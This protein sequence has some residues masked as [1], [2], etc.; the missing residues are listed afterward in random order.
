M[1][2]ISKGQHTDHSTPCWVALGCNP[3]EVSSPHAN[4]VLTA[5]ERDFVHVCRL[6][7]WSAGGRWI[8]WKADCGTPLLNWVAQA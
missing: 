8:Y 3:A 5:W 2:L 1:L 7:F 6:A 4:P